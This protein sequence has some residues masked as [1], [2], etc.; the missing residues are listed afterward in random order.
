[1]RI[2]VHM[3]VLRISMPVAAFGP[4]LVKIKYFSIHL[5]KTKLMPHFVHSPGK[6]Q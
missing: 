2:Y 3:R 4:F 1:M 6:R 5:L